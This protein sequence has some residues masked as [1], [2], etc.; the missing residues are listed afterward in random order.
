MTSIQSRSEDTTSLV[1]VSPPMAVLPLNPSSKLD[2]E[3]NPFEQSFFGA[4]HGAVTSPTSS[5]SVS[6]SSSPQ[7]D[8]RPMLPPVASMTSPA[9]MGALPK[10]VA[11]QFSW[12]SL[13]T[14]PLSPSMLAGP[15]KQA[16]YSHIVATSH[17]QQQSSAVSLPSTRSSPQH[18]HQLTEFTA[19]FKH[20]ADDS[21]KKQDKANVK[22]ESVSS[23]DD[24][25]SC[26]Q[27]QPHTS[28]PAKKRSRP[29]EPEDD[30]KRRNFLERNRIAALKCRQR[31]KQWLNNLQMRAEVLST[32]NEQLQV[33]VETMREEIMNL[34]TLLL[35][36]KDCQVT[37]NSGFNGAAAVAAA[38]AA[39]VPK[40]LPI[41]P[42]EVIRPTSM[43]TNP[44]AIYPQSYTDPER[45][46]PMTATAPMASAAPFPPAIL[47]M[48]ITPQSHPAAQQGMMTAASSSTS[49]IRF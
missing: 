17:N 5:T 4:S 41:M 30:E 11:N 36:H 20:K 25:D 34:K 3:P 38:A 8:T 23:L 27:Q 47:G 16:Q 31:K 7:K 9:V 40:S 1:S 45:S 35:A 48:G 46:Q 42:Q 24:S 29:S 12:D 2:Q 39:A 44:S 33:Q 28:K 21:N 37:Q 18:N 10:D 15:A 6:T 49:I 32:E 26:D 14:G 19:A 22:P 43:A 13:R